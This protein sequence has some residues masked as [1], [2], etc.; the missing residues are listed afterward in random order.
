MMSV[1]GAAWI[2]RRWL[3]L[4]RPW[5]GL[6]AVVLFGLAWLMPSLGGVLLILAVSA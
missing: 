5:S 4:R 3:A 6:T 1:G 2:A